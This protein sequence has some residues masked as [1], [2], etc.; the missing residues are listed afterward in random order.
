MFQHGI[1]VHDFQ[2]F[3]HRENPV[4]VNGCHPVLHIDIVQGLRQQQAK[5]L[6]QLDDSERNKQHNN[7]FNAAVDFDLLLIGFSS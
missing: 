3:H 6:Q 1:T 7:T 5:W 2:Y 4:S